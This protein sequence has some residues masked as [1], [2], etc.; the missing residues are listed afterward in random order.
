[1]TS[2]VT[3]S[4]VNN[5]QANGTASG[6][7]DDA[8]Y[9][10]LTQE[11]LNQAWRMDPATGVASPM[12]APGTPA[13]AFTLAGLKAAGGAIQLDAGVPLP[14]ARLYFSSSPD[15][16]TAP[17]GKISGPTAST[18]DFFYDFVEV[19]LTCTAA[20]PPAHAAPDNLNLDCTQVDQLGIPFTL[21]VTPRDPSFGAGSGIVAT[22]DRQTLVADYKAMAVG[23]L[24]PFADCVYPEGSD[25]STPY[26]LLN[27]N[28][29]INGQLQAASL[30]GTLAVSGS[31]GAWQASFSITGPGTPAPT[32]G[33]LV[34][35]MPVSGP[36]MP[37]G[38]TVGS[39]PGAPSGNTVVI[40]SASS[41]ASN[42]FTASTSPVEL[43]FVT[44]PTTA[45]ATWF[46]AAIDNFFAWCKKN[47]GLLQIEQNN[48]GNHLYTGNLVQVGGIIDISGN[49]NTYTVLQFTGG[50]SETYNLYYPFFSTNSAA[51]KTTPFGADVPPPPAWWTPLKG[52]AYYQ[53]PSAMVFGASGVF[54]DNTQQPLTAPNSSAVLGA[55][56]NVI[57][58]ALG[59]GYATSWKFLQGGITPG[60]PATTATV[61]LSGGATTAGLVDGIDMAS[62]QIAN[63]PMTA[64]IP[65]GAP[66]SSFGVS[67]PLAILPT[68]PGLLTFSQFYPA[69]GTLS[70]FANFL[71]NPAVTIDG[72]AYALPFDDQGGFS[73]DLNAATSVASP[74]GVLLTL[75]AWA[76]GSAGPAVVGGDKLPV[77]LVWQAS[78]DYCFTFLLHYDTSGE[79]STMQI[80]IQGGQFS[81]GYTPP[82]ALQST[83]EIID[84]N[85]VAVGAPYNWGL[86]CNIHVPGFDFEGNAF[87]F[88]TQY[89]N[90][91]P[92]TVWD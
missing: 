91:P 66:V 75:G 79:Y 32:N 68:T 38:A 27:P 14:S 47:P 76:P 26:R 25:A 70:A 90:P 7:A 54:A 92:D 4:I 1:M 83:T 48:N 13:P 56:E 44:P 41:A 71:H 40:S 67:S 31:P 61:S 85:L 81:G 69:G 3:L 46:D 87:E 10:F 19:S 30:Q 37:A 86:W 51:G 77:R 53:P 11:T 9:L 23:P 43:F 45:L 39:L 42:P 62:F 12:P 65:A 6:L 50:N 18:A 57:V 63:I 22:L 73:S 8:I 16:V 21:Q 5:S 49:S 52:L 28:D 17:N 15:A 72:R 82:V 36:L 80:T 64:S 33:G 20:N 59:R 24:A 29:V 2:Y 58:T 78:A 34:V 84:M 74:A 55:I 60:N 88:S 89:N 35:G